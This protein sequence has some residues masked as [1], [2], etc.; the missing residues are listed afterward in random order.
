MSQITLNNSPLRVYYNGEKNF[1]DIKTEQH[2]WTEINSLDH[3]NYWLIVNFKDRYGD[4]TIIC[5]PNEAYYKD[6]AEEHKGQYEVVY[7]PNP[8][9]E[10][11]A[12]T[13]YPR[14]P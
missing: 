9:Q 10:K 5:F 14:R 6:W 12:M 7:Q 4:H 11:Q 8:V 1:I 13:S 3:F 2:W